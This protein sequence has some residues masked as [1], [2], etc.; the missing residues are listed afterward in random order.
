[1]ADK[2]LVAYRDFGFGEAR[3]YL[4]MDVVGPGGQKGP[5]LGL[6]DSG[7]DATVLPA[8]Y[9]PLMGYTPG[10]LVAQQGMQVGGG[11]VMWRATKAAR[12]FVPEIPELVIDFRPCFVQ[13]C[14]TA[15]WGRK[16]LLHHFDVHIMERRKQFLLTPS[17]PSG[18]S[19]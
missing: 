10:D 7:A 9:A 17:A 5:I 14:Q 19:K 11:I 4:F 2:L 12:A 6:I 13:G 16:D 18:A 1:V 3:P 8:G 15:L